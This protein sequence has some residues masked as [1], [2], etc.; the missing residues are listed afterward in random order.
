M[1]SADLIP[2]TLTLP[3]VSLARFAPARTSVILAVTAAFTAILDRLMTFLSLSDAIM[4]RFLGITP[5]LE[6]VVD[7]ADD[8]VRSEEN[9]VAVGQD[10]RLFPTPL[11]FKGYLDV[12]PNEEL[13]PGTEAVARVVSGGAVGK[14]CRRIHKVITHQRHSPRVNPILNLGEYA[15]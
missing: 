14:I 15:L 13:Y 4:F 1:F 5:S 8:S 12:R 9:G 6:N 3:L 2:C 10:H 11:I 7:T